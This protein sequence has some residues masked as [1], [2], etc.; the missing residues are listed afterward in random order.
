MKPE[1]D[2]LGESLHGHNQLN[3][4]QNKEMLAAH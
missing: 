4:R 3:L 1:L 2:M